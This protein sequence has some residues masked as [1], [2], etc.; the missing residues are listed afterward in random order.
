MTVREL[1]ATK[2]IFIKKEASLYDAACLMKRYDIGMLP[3]CDNLGCLEGVVTDRDI[4]LCLSRSD[5]PL[6]EIS[7][8]SAMTKEVV[9]LTRDMD[10]HDAAAVFS[11]HKV[12][13]LPVLDDRRLV[14]ILTLS[15]LASKKVFLA[16]VGEI[17]GA[18][19]K[20]R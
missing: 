19:Q 17:M 11:K 3:V 12:R 16:E 5:T 10:I 7:A 13:R 6:K 18:M 14:G 1:M 2:I 15:D 4:V 20:G 9:S 8:S